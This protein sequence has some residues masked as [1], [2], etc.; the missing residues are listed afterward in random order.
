MRGASGGFCMRAPR[1]ESKAGVS[2]AA[3]NSGLITQD[4]SLRTQNSVARQR[5]QLPI[6]RQGRQASAFRSIV[7]GAG[8]RFIP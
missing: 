2:R 7:T 1:A 6:E 5:Y 4:S 3:D 8:I